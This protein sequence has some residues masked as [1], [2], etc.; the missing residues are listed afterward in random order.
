MQR[1]PAVIPILNTNYSVPPTPAPR[2]TDN[3]QMDAKERFVGMLWIQ[4]DISKPLEDNFIEY[5][6]W[7]PYSETKSYSKRTYAA[8]Y[9]GKMGEY[10]SYLC[11]L[12]SEGK[13]QS[14]PTEDFYVVAKRVRSELEALEP[15]CTC[16]RCVASKFNP[17]KYI[18][19]DYCTRCIKSGTGFAKKEYIDKAIQLKKQAETAKLIPSKYG[20]YFNGIQWIK[21][22]ETFTFATVGLAILWTKY[23]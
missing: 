16:M 10:N 12:N 11:I 3:I 7:E 22:L 14:P 17:M 13:D 15:Y 18:W 21:I 5:D 8:A 9:K 6:H 23:L 4:R 2:S 1:T 20:K 19:C